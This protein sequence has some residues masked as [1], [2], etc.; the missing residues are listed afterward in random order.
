M[1]DGDGGGGGGWGRERESVGKGEGAGGR[2]SKVGEGGD[3]EGRKC[4]YGVGERVRAAGS[5]TLRL[6]PRRVR[7]WPVGE[8]GDDT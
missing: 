6:S 8:G 7:L 1:G 4:L 5:R 3:E 2:E